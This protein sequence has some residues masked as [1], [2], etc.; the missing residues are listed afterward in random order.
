MK[1]RNDFGKLLTEIKLFGNAVEIGVDQGCFAE[2]VLKDWNGRL[3]FMVDGWRRWDGYNDLCDRDDALMEDIY[4][5]VLK[6]FRDDKRAIPIRSFSVEAAMIFQPSFFDFVYID[7]DHT[8]ES[9][10]ADIKAWWPKARSGAV[11][12]G[13]DYKEGMGI[14]QAVGELVKEHSLELHL[15]EED[16][17]S[18]WVIK[19]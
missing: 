8:Y 1:T 5:R 11:F 3:Y 4:Q 18:W 19:P 14:I 17:A 7:A 13:H 6:K 16:Y 10:K 12:A 15:T 9:V 2:E